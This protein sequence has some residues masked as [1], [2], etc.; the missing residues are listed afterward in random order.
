[1]GGGYTSVTER[2]VR[3]ERTT[4]VALLETPTVLTPRDSSDT[5]D[6]NDV[7]LDTQASLDVCDQLPPMDTPRTSEWQRSFPRPVTIRYSRH[8]QR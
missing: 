4:D 7:L 3:I 1:M 2:V 6:P 8:Q 5:F